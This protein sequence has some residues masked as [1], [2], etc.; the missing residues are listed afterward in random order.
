M[1][2]IRAATLLF[3]EKLTAAKESLTAFVLFAPMRGRVGFVGALSSDVI[4][5]AAS[6]E[7]FQGLFRI[8]IGGVE[9]WSFAESQ[10]SEIARCLQ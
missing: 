8:E 9:N 6:F 10:T 5:K 1:E 4:C 2:C 7:C 3:F